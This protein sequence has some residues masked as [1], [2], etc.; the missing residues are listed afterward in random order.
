[1]GFSEEKK[2]P[3]LRERHIFYVCS[4]LAI[5]SITGED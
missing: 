5:N 1:V 2:I 3:M 4:Q